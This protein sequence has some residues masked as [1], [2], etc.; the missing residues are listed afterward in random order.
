MFGEDL[1]A[2]A[3]NMMGGNRSGI[4]YAQQLPFSGFGH[5]HLMDSKLLIAGLKVQQRL[6]KEHYMMIKG[7]AAMHDD[8][9]DGI[10]KNKPIWGAQLAYAYNSI[11]GPLG[12]S[13]SWSDLTKQVYLYINLGFEF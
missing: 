3:M 1:P 12:G 9:M 13:I 7:H 5:C 11:V 4:Y 10:F 2:T 6:F 8:K